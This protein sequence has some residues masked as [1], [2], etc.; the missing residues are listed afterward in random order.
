MKTSSFFTILTLGFAL[1]FAASNLTFAL[2]PGRPQPP[3]PPRHEVNPEAKL[4]RFSTTIEKERPELDEETKRLI[5]AYRR[6]PTPQNYDALR[7]KVAANYDAV[8]ARKVGKLEELKREARDRSKVEEMQVIVDEVIRDREAR[9][10]ATMARFTDER[11]GP[12]MHYDTASGY[13]PVLGAP[14]RNVCIALFPVTVADYARFTGKRPAPGK[15]NH[16]VTGVSIAD[17]QRYCKWLTE[18]DPQHIY[19]LAT[20]S[21]WELAAGHMP[22]DA[23][24]NCGVARTTTPVDAYAQTKGACGG[25]DFWGNCWEWTS[26]ER[27][28]GVNGVKG[29][30]YDSHRTAC[31]TEERTEGRKASAGYPNVTF[32][33]V[34]ED[35]NSA[36]PTQFNGGRNMPP[37]ARSRGSQSGPQ[38]GPRP[39]GPAGQGNAPRPQGA[40][41]K[42]RK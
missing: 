8:I 38:N 24:F 40:H 28:K 11:F 29:G 42:P 32:R 33:V 3:Q 12:G 35:L 19:R 10:N 36:P 17:A 7:A 5:S 9:I 26:T 1:L 20:E 15:E 27:R 22:K 25:A 39:N 21:E 37:A 34:R 6:N 30:A 2:G 18:R 23:D 31:R 16:P 4:H 41:G 14:G 13:A